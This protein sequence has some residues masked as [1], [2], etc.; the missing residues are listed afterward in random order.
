MF[1]AHYCYNFYRNA[2][3][4]ITADAPTP[5]GNVVSAHCFVDADHACDRATRRFHTGVLIFV[6][7][8]PILWYSKQYYTVKT[9][10]FYS[11]FI[12]LKTVN[13]LVDALWYKLRMFGIPIE[14]PTNMF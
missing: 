1:Y 12:A 6:N 11:E 14:G 4:A 13:E 2:K 9:S 7:K 3:E 10:T 8:A 5:R